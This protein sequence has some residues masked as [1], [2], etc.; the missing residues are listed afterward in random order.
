MTQLLIHLPDNDPTASAETKFGGQPSAPAGEL[1]WPV[2]KSCD[3][4]MQF[5]GQLRPGDSEE[6][7]LLFMCQNDPGGCEEWDPNDGGNAVVG[8]PAA[9]LALVK[10]PA[11]GDVVRPV[12]HGATTATVAGDNYEQAREHWAAGHDVSPREVLGQ[13]GGAPSW[14]QGDEVPECDG[15]NQPMD[16]AAQLEQGPDWQ[17]EMNFGGGGSAY[18][19]RCTCANGGAKMLWQC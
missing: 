3:G 6:L 16:F 12:R 7:L 9:D 17:T 14:L 15:C 19:F 5:L 1:S 13:L 4:H 8:V 18:V 10:P 11:E 2:Y